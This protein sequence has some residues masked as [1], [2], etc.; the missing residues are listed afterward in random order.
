MATHGP[1]PSMRP[2][3]RANKLKPER[4]DEPDFEKNSEND[5]RIIGVTIEIDGK[6]GSRKSAK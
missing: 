5:G 1:F 2:V 6:K 4:I 3:S